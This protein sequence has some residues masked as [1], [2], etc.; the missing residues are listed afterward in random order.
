L[1]FD[2]DEPLA[3]LLVILNAKRPRFPDLLVHFLIHVRQFPQDSERVGLLWC[4][5]GLNFYCNTKILADL[6]D[7]EANSVQ[8]NFREHG[9]K[10][11]KD[12]PRRFEFSRQ[13]HVWGHP[14]LRFACEVREAGLMPWIAPTP[15]ATPPFG[16]MRPSATSEARA[17][18]DEQRPKRYETDRGAPFDFDV[19]PRS[20]GDWLWRFDDSPFFF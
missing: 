12:K 13:W 14:A 6:L 16:A 7:L 8:H 11:D 19:F 5:D 1:F 17:N 3:R 4:P 18:D 9:I 10:I 20:D 2:Q 15:K